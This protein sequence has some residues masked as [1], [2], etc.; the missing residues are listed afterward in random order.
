MQSTLHKDKIF[1][2]VTDSPE[3]AE[4][5]GRKEVGDKITGK[6]TASLDEKADG[7]CVF[8]IDDITVEAGKG[9]KVED[10]KDEEEDEPTSVQ[11]MKSVSGEGEG[12]YP[13]AGP[14]ENPEKEGAVS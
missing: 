8:S 1:L 14:A 3:L 11:A 7:M 5:I 2:D 13:E 9:K 10:S 12:A 4:L 6:F